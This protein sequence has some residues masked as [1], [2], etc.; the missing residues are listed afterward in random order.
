MVERALIRG[1]GIEVIAA[2]I[3]GGTIYV[4]VIVDIAVGTLGQEEFLAY[5]INL[6][7]CSAGSG[8]A[9]GIKHDIGLPIASEIVAARTLEIHTSNGL[10]DTIT[11]F[12][13]HEIVK[14][15]TLFGELDGTF[16][17][18]FQNYTLIIACY[19]GI[20][21]FCRRQVAVGVGIGIEEL[22]QFWS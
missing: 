12:P 20:T 22:F 17:T 4:V 14:A 1:D 10:V 13:A 16:A 5:L 6:S 9:F 8:C 2:F 21:C 7:Y 11:C 19:V 15:E 3:E 18:D